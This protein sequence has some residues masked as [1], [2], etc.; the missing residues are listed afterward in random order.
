M[1]RTRGNDGELLI[2][3]GATASS[4]GAGV[5][6]PVNKSWRDTGSLGSKGLQHEGF[7]ALPGTQLSRAVT[8]FFGPVMKGPW[9]TGVCTVFLRRLCH[10][11]H[12]WLCLPWLEIR[13]DKCVSRS[14][15]GNPA[16]CLLPV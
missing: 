16:R 5:G 7:W 15:V 4:E 9:P 8:L 3:H 12:S 10:R 6:T 11:Q 13:R 14:S 2:Q 1:T